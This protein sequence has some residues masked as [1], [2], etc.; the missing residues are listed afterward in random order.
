MPQPNEVVDLWLYFDE[1]SRCV[2]SGY[3]RDRLYRYGKFDSCNNQWQDL[4]KAA[5]AK[6]KASKKEAEAI[7][8]E[9]YYKQHL[10]SD[11]TKSPTAG[12]I[13]DLK[14]KPGWD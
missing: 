8:G 2:G 12:V 1:W 7:L 11:Q 5:V 6:T 14:E 3:Q 4:K 10:G 13:W 9:T